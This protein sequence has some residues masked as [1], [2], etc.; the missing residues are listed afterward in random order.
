MNSV[1]RTEI[2]W[3]FLLINENRDRKPNK[4]KAMFKFQFLPF[5]HMKIPKFLFF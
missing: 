2:S 3:S 1:F 4:I 5:D